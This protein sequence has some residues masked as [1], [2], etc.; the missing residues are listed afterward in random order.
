MVEGSFRGLVI[1]FILVGLFMFTILTFGINVATDYGYEADDVTG[2]AVDLSD[3]KNYVNSVSPNA[4][5]GDEQF[6][7][8][9]T[10][11]IVATDT[12]TGIWDVGKGLG[13]MITTPFR[14]VGAVLETIFGIDK[15]IIGV[16]VGIVGLLTIFG[17][18]AT[19]RI[20]K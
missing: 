16:F 13:I 18:W 12:L 20:G 9:G 5:E 6:T 3:I 11:T 10:F 14:F 8:A 2:G 17:I 15:P 7:K 4:S 1:G 19:V